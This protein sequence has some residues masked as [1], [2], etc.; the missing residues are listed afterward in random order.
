MRRNNQANA[1]L[2]ELLIVIL[3]FMLGSVILIRVFGKAYEMTAEARAAGEAMAE[4]QSVADTLYACGGDEGRL[5][6][7]GFA[8]EETG[9]DARWIR[10]GDGYDL[11][12]FMADEPLTYGTMRRMSVEAVRGQETLLHIPCSRYGG[13]SKP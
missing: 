10:T 11:Q 13:E 1:L 3:F 4:A 9:S 2:V 6:E 8:R 7:M 12:V 5:E